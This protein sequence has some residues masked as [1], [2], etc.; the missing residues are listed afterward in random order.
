MQTRPSGGRVGR[1]PDWLKKRIT[2]SPSTGRVR[3]LLSELRLETVCEQAHCP[4]LCECYGRGTATFLILGP[5]CTRS[6]RF[7][8]VASGPPTPVDES[9]PERVA[10]ASARLDLKH[11]VVTS[12]TR[13]D[14]PDGG[15][16]QF[17]RTVRAIR[18]RC[19]ALVEVLTPDFQGDA[20]AIRTVLAAR[21]DIYNHNI[22]TVP[23]LMAAIRP[24]A[25][26]ERSLAVLRLAGTDGDSVLT[27]SGLMVGLGE[28]PDEVVEVLRDLRAA[29]CDAVTI[30]HYLAPSGA[31]F[32]VHEFVPPQQ[33]DS[34]RRQAEA[35]GFR[36]V[37]AGPFVRSSYHA[38]D[39]FAHASCS[40][41][42]V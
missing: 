37:A 15:A 27:K 14:L 22:E 42:I 36:A 11:V 39:L 26:Y 28:T 4:N 25:R 35:L 20:E 31:H 21:P 12:V 29:G 9:E 38:E 7:C 3:S 23:R 5:N 2:V 40:G 32:P 33:F 41:G 10:E 8:A 13:D 17:A 1:F 34:Y 6:C 16:G 19:G 18:E 30:G 24:E